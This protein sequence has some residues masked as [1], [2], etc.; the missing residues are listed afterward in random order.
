VSSVN[1]EMWIKVLDRMDWVVIIRVTMALQ[2][3]QCFGDRLN[4]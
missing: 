4:I 3:F 1:G 2:G